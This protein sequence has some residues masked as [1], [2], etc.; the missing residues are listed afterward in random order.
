[1]A[2]KPG[3]KGS[4][5]GQ[6][7]ETREILAFDPGPEVMPD[8][9]PG[10]VSPALTAPP[11][12]LDQTILM[13]RPVRAK[14]SASTPPA[15][16]IGAP[17]S[18]SPEPPASP[19]RPPRPSSKAGPPRPRSTSIPPKPGDSRP[20]ATSV[21]SR[22]GRSRRSAPPIASRPSASEPV[23]NVAS[24]KPTAA[25][26]QPTGQV[27]APKPASEVKVSKATAEVASTRSA[28]SAAESKP[29]ANAKVSEPASEGKASKRAAVEEDNVPSAA[30]RVVRKVVSAPKVSPAPKVVAP[31]V[32][33][34]KVVAPVVSA[35][36]VVAPVV[37]APKV[38]PRPNP[39]AGPTPPPAKRPSPPAVST[40]SAKAARRESTEELDVTD[41]KISAPAPEEPQRSSGVG[42]VLGVVAAVIAVVAV[43]VLVVVVGTFGGAAAF[44]LKP[45]P[46]GP[47][48]LTQVVDTKVP[49]AGSEPRPLVIGAVNSGEPD[50]GSPSDVE[51]SGIKPASGVVSDD[52]PQGEGGTVDGM[53]APDAGEE[54]VAALTAP[55]GSELIGA[56][57]TSVDGAEAA[58]GTEAT[59]SPEPSTGSAPE[60]SEPPPA[61]PSTT[62][63]AGE[64]DGG[65]AVEVNRSGRPG[66]DGSGVVSAMQRTNG[67]VTVAGDAVV[68][69]VKGRRRVKV[70]GPV[71]A[72]KYMIEAKFPGY[73]QLKR[74]GEVT[75]KAN[76]DMVI[77]CDA[78]LKIC[79]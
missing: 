46:N 20:V 65:Q 28:P 16:P 12:P 69:L 55:D 49:E 76:K 39:A 63:V 19:P 2:G 40:V 18:S 62:P 59:T 23:V 41:P 25:E 73:P 53:E 78:S 21:A 44:W 70:P 45:V 3:D 24:L 58:S 10:A 36:K 52:Y 9:L 1:M 75:V 66:I 32:S 67:N 7:L 37:S 11:P 15:G 35:P 54:V 31:V 17:P 4:E 29:A 30:K 60:A 22:P 74:F 27:S 13:A 42:C 26:S 71:P 48:E 68:E 14:P 64:Y 56:D 57:T 79:R 43:L 34:P 77:K 5:K 33:A 72:G 47:L 51:P 8:T 6:G 61:P 50:A 38:S